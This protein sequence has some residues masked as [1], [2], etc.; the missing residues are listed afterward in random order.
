MV[1]VADVASAVAGMVADGDVVMPGDV[2][3]GLPAA[4]VAGCV[5]PAVSKVAARVR[6]TRTMEG[7]GFTPARLSMATPARWFSV[8]VHTAGDVGVLR[9]DAVAAPGFWL[10][11]VRAPSTAD[12]VRIM[13][14]R[15]RRRRAGSGRSCCTS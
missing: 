12:A 5:H 9:G 11:L 13:Y 1:G 2:S 4:V 8:D 14:G 10:W 15:R 7:R 3:A 6:P